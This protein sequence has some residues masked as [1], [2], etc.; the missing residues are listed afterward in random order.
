M[1]ISTDTAPKPSVSPQSI[2]Q[3]ASVNGASVDAK[4]F[5][6]ARLTGFGGAIASGLTTTVKAQESADGSTGWTD[7]TGATMSFAD[8]D[9]DSVKTV[10]IRLLGGTRK[11]YLRA[12]VTVASGTGSN[13]FGA[14]IDLGSPHGGQRKPVQTDEASV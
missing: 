5:A 4:E 8:T 9:D 14:W 2:A 3:G 7:I 12:V 6:E 10:A 1:D 11:R 13:L